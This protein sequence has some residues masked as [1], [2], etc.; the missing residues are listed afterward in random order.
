MHWSLPFWLLAAAGFLLSAV[1]HIGTFIG[2]NFDAMVPFP[3]GLHIGIFIV[4]LPAIIVSIKDLKKAGINSNKAESQLEIWKRS[5]KFAPTWMKFLPLLLIPYVLFNFFF[6]GSILMQWGGPSIIDGQKVLSSHGTIIRVLTDDEFFTQT[7][8]EIRLFSGHWMALYATAWVL[9]YS[10]FAS[11]LGWPEPGRPSSDFVP[12]IP[13]LTRLESDTSM[14]W[15]SIKKSYSCERCGYEG[16]GP[17]TIGDIAGL[18]AKISTGVFIVGMV[19]WSVLVLIPTLM[20]SIAAGLM[21]G[22]LP[23]KRRCPRCSPT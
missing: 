14:N 21:E 7:L 8:Y 13:E 2:V 16:R 3:F 9:L 4:F 10:H 12:P 17:W 11:K 1:M 22:F 20:V 15:W 19:T 18:I 6:T 5:T 23:G